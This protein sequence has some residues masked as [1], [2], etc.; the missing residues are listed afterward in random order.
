[1]RRTVVQ[2]F[3]W[4]AM[5]MAV[6]LFGTQESNARLQPYFVVRNA[7]VETEITPRILFVLDTSGSMTVAASPG[8][9]T[10]AWEE[11]EEE[12]FYGTTSESRISAARRAVNEVITATGDEAK[13]AL[14]TFDQ[15]GPHTPGAFIPQCWNGYNWRRFV[16]V[17]FSYYPTQAWNAI[18]R[19]GHVGAWR[20]CQGFSQRPYPYL[21]WDNLGLGQTIV[22]NNQ[23]GAV[24]S[25]PM[26]TTDNFFWISNDF[27]ARRRVQ[28]FPT[29]MGVRWQPNDATDPGRTMTYASVGDYGATQAWH[30][31][32][33]WEHDFYYWPYVDGFPGYSHWNAYPYYTGMATSG[34]VGTTVGA[35][36]AHLYSP[37]YLDLDGLGVDPAN[38]GP[39]TEEEAR[40][41]VM[42]H[43]SP[44]IYGG[45]DSVGLTPW[46]SAIGA[47]PGV[48]P[49]TNAAYSHPTVASYIS[50]VNS[51]ETGDVCAP[52]AVVLITD[53]EPYPA[54]EG[55]PPLYDRLAELRR[56]L[57]AQTYVVG[58]FLDAVSLN[59]MAC[60]AAGACDGGVC[61]TP[62]DDEPQ[63]QWDTCADPDNPDTSCAYQASSAAELQ[64]VLTGIVSRIGDLDV[65]SGPGSSA[66]EFGLENSDGSDLEALQTTVSAATDFPGWQGHVIRAACDTRDDSG[67]LLPHCVD[68]GFADEELEETFGPCP[69][70]RTWDAGE[71]LAIT[72]CEDRR[73]YTNDENNEPILISEEDGESSD[74]FADL[75]EHMGIIGGADAE[76]EA[77]AIASFLLG[78]EAPGDWKLPGLANSAPIIVRRIPPYRSDFSPSVA[79]TDPHCGGRLLG[80]GDGVPPS[81]EQYAEDVWD[82][83]NL[84]T[85]P[86][87]HYEAQEAV[88]IGDD[89]GVLHA[90]QL[91]SGNE[92]WGFIPS[93]LLEAAAEKTEVGPGTY[94]QTA[95]LEDHNYGL[96][97]TINYG[98]V[99]DDTP[100]DEDDHQWRQ[101]A[102]LGMG[103]GGAEHMVLDLSH[104]SPESP[105]E[106]FEIMWT[107]EDDELVDDYDEF[108]GETWARPALG[109]HVP[110]EV[111]SQVPDAYFVMGSGYPVDAGE[112]N[113]GRTLLQVDA[114]TGEIED[115]AVLPAP[116]D[117]NLFE[118]EFGTVVD[119]AVGTHCLS[120]L[121]A[122]MQE[123]Y[124]TD[125]A[126]RLFRWDLG[127]ETNHEADSGGVWGNA[128]TPAISEPLLACLGSG[129]S[130]TVGAGDYAETF[131]FSP[132]ITSNDRLDD[133]TSASSA[134]PLSPT[135]Q[136]L[137]ALISGTPAD[138]ALRD[139]YGSRFHSSLY[140]IADDHSGDASEGIEIPAGAPKTA[141]GEDDSFVRIAL[142]DIERTRTIV[143]FEG[144]DELVESR[145]FS[146][147]TR[148]IRAP[149]IFVTGAVDENTVDDDVPTVIDGVEVYFIEFT[150]YEP[151][152]E[153][154][155]RAF[156]DVANAEW[157]PDP[158]STYVLTFRLTADVASGFDLL[159]G[160]GNDN[161]GDDGDGVDFGDG[162]ET[163]L[164]FVSVDQIGTGDC[165]D[166][167]CGPL[168]GNP[169]SA[170]CDNNSGGANAAAGTG[171]ALA[172]THK[173]LSAFTPVE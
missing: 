78:C 39:A 152:A 158:G 139:G 88:L 94:G 74:E 137:I 167:G 38:T 67:E 34:V 117:G 60:A 142:T 113:Q 82:E 134:G 57:G 111:S 62:C 45:V 90:F 87:D 120:R 32:F 154:C 128:A 17:Q 162:N 127:R 9:A 103:A 95:E 144:A 140:I 118:P 10:C 63:S 85:S 136:F 25:S 77:D 8:I 138:D 21:R 20:L 19:D 64:T 170:P 76:D 59:D 147:G 161:G 65:P 43:T 129:D 150:V 116:T 155:D 72:D 159:N 165:A 80:A 69:Q 169:F 132:A 141:P 46:Y 145:N 123:V 6:F 71:C 49:N 42:S 70:S 135:D 146:R 51:V 157:H 81:L 100:V 12:A 2:S 75:L 122:E 163:G 156:Y 29:F 28:W 13:F 52:T 107:T 93:Y 91:N 168:V 26:I 166:G 151:P 61:S 172:V 124:V 1:M 18:T 171:A 44:I 66:N 47:D 104:M 84:L 92:M 68:P 105:R 143:P 114:L 102:I 73:I 164:S 131:A 3:K 115:Y 89:F 36:T 173:E 121:W 153:V 33:V 23:N 7:T 99:F 112:P 119:P 35:Q 130:C 133:V 160:A 110:G 148:P 5:A 86:S 48:A 58:F 16:W 98:W 4:L 96:A 125:P 126:G 56:T 37:F 97:S 149:R 11:C 79:I 53:G 30:D 14:M 109:Y 106:P 22:A 50:F 55:G 24:P 54:N 41:Q 31:F 40:E 15:H 27:N 83:D 108:N 101:L